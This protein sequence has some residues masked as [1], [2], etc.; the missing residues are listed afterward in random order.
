MHIYFSFLKT[1]IAKNLFQTSLH[2]FLEYSPISHFYHPGTSILQILLVNCAPLRPTDPHLPNLTS[3][4][5]LDREGNPDCS[6]WSSCKM[7][8]KPV[9]GALPGA[10]KNLK[11]LNPQGVL[12]VQ[13]QQVE[14]QHQFPEAN[15]RVKGQQLCR[16][17]NEVEACWK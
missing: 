7:G 14:G 4:E 2:F 6:T 10:A 1:H 17:W 5:G 9:W 3:S 13:T 8:P 16:S 11:S 15:R 12:A